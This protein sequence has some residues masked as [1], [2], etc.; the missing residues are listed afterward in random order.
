MK[1]LVTGASGF[2]GK[3]LLSQNL[4]G[5]IHVVSRNYCLFPSEITPHFGDLGNEEFIEYLGAQKFDRVIHLA[6]D[7]L[8]NLSEQNNL[9]NFC[10]SKQLLEVLS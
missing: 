9:R 1:T 4:S 10:I 5:D 7:G 6:W 8:P 2:I 3:A